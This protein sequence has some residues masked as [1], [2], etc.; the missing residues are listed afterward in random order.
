MRAAVKPLHSSTFRSP[1]LPLRHDISISWRSSGRF[2]APYQTLKMFSKLSVV[3]TST[4]AAAIPTNT[5]PT[6][7]SA[8]CCSSVQ[9]SDQVTAILGPVVGGLLDVLLGGI[10]VPVGL[11]CSP[12]TVIG[13][14]CG[15][16]TVN[17]DSTQNMLPSPL[18]EA[19]GILAR[20]IS[21]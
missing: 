8:Q 21:A 15:G 9:S 2:Q 19:H 5:P 6:T 14:N 18:T 4:L 17:C 13:N 3:V 7:P 20:T 16:T 10:A 12:I 11:G 1:R